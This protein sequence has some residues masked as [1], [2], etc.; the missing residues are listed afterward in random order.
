MTNPEH[1]LEPGH[2]LVDGSDTTIVDLS[3]E[4]RVAANGLL[5]IIGRLEAENAD[6]R[7]ANA[8]LTEEKG[9]LEQIA[10]TDSLTGVKSRRYFD[11]KCMNEI[12]RFIAAREQGELRAFPKSILLCFADID[13]LK[14]V[15]D[16]HQDKHAAGDQLIRAVAD[17]LRL[18]IRPSDTICRYGGDEFVFM[19]RVATDDPDVLRKLPS[20]VHQ[21]AVAKATSLYGEPITFSLGF[22]D[23]SDYSS[24]QEAMQAADTEMYH[25]KVARNSFDK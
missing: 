15:N 12:E 13:G 20:L 16:E 1:S 18:A 22:V 14:K 8:R 21:R 3:T 5:A 9:Q 19:L 4:A 17:G 24:A 10:W 25:L 7:E 6:L 11:E 23:V 2:K